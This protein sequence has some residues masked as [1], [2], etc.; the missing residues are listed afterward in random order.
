MAKGG[1]GA[2]VLGVAALA[3]VGL[4]FAAGKIPGYGQGTPDT[5]KAGDA[6]KGAGGKAVEGA[7][8][9]AGWWF[10]HGWAYTATVAAVL[11]I[12]GIMTWNRIGGWGRAVVIVLAAVAVTVLV[13]R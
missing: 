8:G 7:T 10:S 1:G 9:L 12:L 5:S 2:L 11:A 13:T 3:G 6:A 4:L